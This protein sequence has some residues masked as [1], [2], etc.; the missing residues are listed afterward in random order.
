MRVIKVSRQISS[1]HGH[2]DDVSGDWSVCWHEIHEV[3]PHSK[4]AAARPNLD[5]RASA[6]LIRPVTNLPTRIWCM[7]PKMAECLPLALGRSRRLGRAY[8]EADIHRSAVEMIS[9]R[10]IMSDVQAT[11]LAPPLAV[12]HL[13]ARVL[14]QEAAKRLRLRRVQSQG[15][16]YQAI[17]SVAFARQLDDRQSA[18]R[19]GHDIDRLEPPHAALCTPLLLGRVH[20]HEIVG[21]GRRPQTRCADAVNGRN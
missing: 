17:T 2:F 4:P 13:N 7:A 10:M 18:S 1:E 6:T 15:S 5:E 14:T 3:T 12:K 19:R 11:L 9:A 21:Q 8:T 16:T 20:L